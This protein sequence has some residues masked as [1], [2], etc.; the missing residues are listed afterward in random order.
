MREP[1]LVQTEAA[2]VLACEVTLDG[3]EVEADI[4]AYA[5]EVGR[6]Q[7]LIID[8]TIAIVPPCADDL[9]TTFDY[10]TIRDFVFELAAQ[11]IVLI[12]TFAGRLAKMCL[13]DPAALAADV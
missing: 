8:V 9:N 1:A 6:P 5:R 11:R 7:P 12:E 2:S 13:A 10:A 3:I 4:G